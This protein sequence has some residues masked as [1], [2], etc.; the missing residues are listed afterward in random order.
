MPAQHMFNRILGGG[1]VQYVTIQAL[2]GMGPSS[3]IIPHKQ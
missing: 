3:R 1:V 2:T